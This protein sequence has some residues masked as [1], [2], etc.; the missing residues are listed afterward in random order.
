M[1]K[2]LNKITIFSIILII[3]IIFFII[4]SFK[5]PIDLD[6]F[7]KNQKNYIILISDNN[8]KKEEWFIL[9]N[10]KDILNFNIWSYYYKLDIIWDYIINFAIKE[11]LENTRVYIKTDYLDIF[12]IK[13]QSSIKITKKDNNL[14]IDTLVWSIDVFKKDNIIINWNYN[15]INK[16]E[17]INQILQKIN[18]EL[19]KHILEQYWWNIITNNTINKIIQIKL[20]LLYNIKPSKY[21]KNLE[22]Y[23]NF[24][25]FLKEI[26]INIEN[27]IKIEKNET[28]KINK[29]I[30][31]E[32]KKWLDKIESF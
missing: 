20:N 16:N 3:I 30:Y 12:E 25:I 19:K 23:K 15:I 29:D 22:N 1:S 9:L 2:K 28:K 14:I 8:L 4:P 6:S 21:E 7:Y 10:N 5:K 31:N 13:K 27:Y 32:F 11:N 24:V 17:D 18:L 26:G